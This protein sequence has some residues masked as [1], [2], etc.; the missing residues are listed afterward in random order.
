MLCL[1]LHDGTGPCGSDRMVV[2]HSA[3]GNADCADDCAMFVFQRQSAGKRDQPAVGMFDVV[4]RSARLRQFSDFTGG[5]IEKTRRFRL[6]Y[7]DIH[8]PQPGL[9]HADEGLEIR[10]RIDYG[11]VHFGAD[12]F[13]LF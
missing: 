4:K 7:R 13:G 8:A 11:D 9:V 2:F 1:T 5:H 12:F 10:A 6:F 3:A